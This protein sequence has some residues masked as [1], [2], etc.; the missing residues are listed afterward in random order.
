MYPIVSYTYN[1]PNLSVE[2]I[3]SRK[4][5]NCYHIYEYS[6][7]SINP[8]PTTVLNSLRDAGLFGHGQVTR[9]S[10]PVVEKVLCDVRLINEYTREVMAEGYEN[11]PDAK[12]S[13]QEV[14]V[15]KATTECDSGG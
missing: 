2:H 1:K 15:Y 8:L 9:F 12:P 3:R 4:A 11:I 7:R 5:G 14:Y 13:Y 10:E 6:V